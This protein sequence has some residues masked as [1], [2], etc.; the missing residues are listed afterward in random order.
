MPRTLTLMGLRYDCMFT[1]NFDCASSL[2]IDQEIRP[3]TLTIYKQLRNANID[4]PITLNPPTIPT[5]TQDLC[6]PACP[7]KQQRGSIEYTMFLMHRDCNIHITAETNPAPREYAEWALT[8]QH[9]SP[10]QL[11]PWV[12]TTTVLVNGVST[13]VVVPTATSSTVPVR[14]PAAAAAP[15]PAQLDVF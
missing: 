11:P 12:H 3:G 6:Y 8:G 5:M 2:E 14:E 4:S 1:P 15:V 13:V 10:I 9:E 7:L